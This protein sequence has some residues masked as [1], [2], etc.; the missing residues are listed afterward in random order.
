MSCS[1]EV[2]A[3]RLMRASVSPISLA[4][5]ATT[6]VFPVPGGPS[7]SSGHPVLMAAKMRATWL[8]KV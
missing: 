2:L 1:S 4:T 8:M 5:S 6:A 7:S 3:E